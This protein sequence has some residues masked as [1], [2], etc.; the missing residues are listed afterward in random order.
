MGAAGSD[1]LRVRGQSKW[2]GRGPAKALYLGRACR[3]LARLGR[4]V[5][6]TAGEMQVHVGD[7]DTLA[8]NQRGR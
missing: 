2:L 3:L 6:S 1:A 4:A 7:G 5:S 8:A